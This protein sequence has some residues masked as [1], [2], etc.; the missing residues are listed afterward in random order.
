MKINTRNPLLWGLTTLLC[1]TVIC[2][3]AAHGGRGGGGG[4][5]PGGGGGIGAGGGG[6]RPSAP[7]ARPS[8]SPAARPSPSPA[9]RPTTPSARPDVGSA[10]SFGGAG[11]PSTGPANAG[12]ARTGG[13][14]ESNI[15]PG[16][17]PN[18]G[19]NDRPAV[20]TRPGID[21]RPAIDNRPP[22]GNRPGV[23]NRPAVAN[24]PATLP[25]IA[26]RPNADN[27]LPNGGANIA[28]R[29]DD[30]QN[31]LQNQ[32]NW[33]NGR[34]DR[35]NWRDNNREDW[36]NWA[37]DN[38]GDW[39]HG[40]CYGGYWNHMWNEHPGWAAFGMTAWGVNRLAYG[41][42]L[43]A[44]SNPYYSAQATPVYDYSQPIIATT[45]ASGQPP[46]EATPPASAMTAFDQA[47]TD[48]YNG[49]YPAALNG[50]NQAVKEMPQD[51]VVHEFRALVLFAL[52]Q[53]NDA[54]AT[55][56]PVLA[57]GPGWDWA[58]LAGLYPT[59]DIYTH[60][61]RKLEESCKANPKA[62]GPEFLLAYHYLTCD[63]KD[64]AH[65]SFERVVSLQPGDTV[66]A[67]YVRLTDTTPD[68]AADPT[69][70]PPS[71]AEIPADQLIDATAVVGKWKASAGS[72][73]TFALDLT[74]KGEFT[75]TYKQGTNSQTLKG[76][77]ALDQNKLALQP[78]SGG[79]MLADLSKKGTGFH[80]AQE[81]APAN[82][83]GLDFTK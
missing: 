7:A 52:G 16:N 2:H 44:Y 59:I 21:N 80:F 51:A 46:V 53:Y 42:G 33:A 56:H 69:P 76:A 41:F 18:I 25:G 22:T 20:G 70:E 1:V 72:G 82:D 57:V 13:A 32:G 68:N 78:D 77:Y 62:A 9:A 23:D 36:Q 66:A 24:R 79:T 3:E 64:A 60:Q 38:H 4:G 26:N 73:N 28:D 6:A 67:D 55:I 40:Y 47:R 30:L 31:R 29:H 10:P 12:G 34:E 14:G 15:T 39:H 27:R 49:D 74:D 35:Q 54:A 58:T 17:R 63:H 48:F 61:L 19:A 81:G 8:P 5:R 11:R 75:W 43:G 71:V 83:P 45:D 37:S 65:R 50:A